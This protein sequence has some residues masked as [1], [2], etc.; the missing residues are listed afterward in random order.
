MNRR[1][2]IFSILSLLYNIKSFALNMKSEIFY[3]L[4]SNSFIDGMGNSVYDISSLDGKIFLC[5]FRKNK[6]TII[7]VEKKNII[8]SLD[9]FSPHGIDITKKGK[10]YS[11][12]M[13]KNQI[14]LFKKNLFGIYNLKKKSSNHILSNPV[15]VAFSSKKNLLY[16]ANWIRKKNNNSNDIIA[17]DSQ[18]DN[19]HP[20]YNEEGKNLLHYIAI[21][22]SKIYAV[23]RDPPSIVVLNE[24][25][26]K[27]DEIIFDSSIDPL[28]I[29]YFKNNFLLT[30]YKNGKIH[31]LNDQF[32]TTNLISLE[33]SSPTNTAIMNN[34]IYVVEESGNRIFELTTKL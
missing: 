27:I 9:I 31:V 33:S 7:D 21:F 15:S 14:Y 13:S 23:Y 20:F 30:N 16:I 4:N 28:S 19:F 2:F 10:I 29:N 25:S 5:E 1:I 6:I 11:A 34:K 3:Y 24:E 32:E 12:S 17:A 22:N 8:K 26:K 18:L